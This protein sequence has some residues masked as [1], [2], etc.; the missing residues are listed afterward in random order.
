MQFC[1]G[2]FIESGKN[3]A[4]LVGCVFPRGDEARAGEY[5]PVGRNAEISAIDMAGVVP[6]SFPGKQELYFVL[7][8]AEIEPV[9]VLAAFNPVSGHFAVLLGEPFEVFAG[10]LPVEIHAGRHAPEALRM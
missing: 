6:V 5:V 9:S 8:C 2:D 1:T 4:L 3:V 10:P 7:D